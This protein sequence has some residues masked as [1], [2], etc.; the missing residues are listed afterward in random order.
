MILATVLLQGAA[1]VEAGKQASMSLLDL[2]FAGGWVM[3]PITLLSF[4]ALYIFIERYVVI[5]QA[6]REDVNFMN[7]IKDY[8]HDGKVDAALQ[9]C[10]STNSPAARMVEKGLT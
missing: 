2:Y 8:M 1:G 6:A 3:Y 5:K 7:R 4:V 10:R 9:L